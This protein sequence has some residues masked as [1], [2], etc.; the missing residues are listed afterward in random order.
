MVLSLAD[1][2]CTRVGCGSFAQELEEVGGVEDLEAELARIGR[3]I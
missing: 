1:A 3:S 2:F